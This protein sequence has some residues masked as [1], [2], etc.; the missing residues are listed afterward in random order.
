MIRF[1]SESDT[2][3]PECDKPVP[4]FLLVAALSSICVDSGGIFF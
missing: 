4:F 1:G 3:F 2:K